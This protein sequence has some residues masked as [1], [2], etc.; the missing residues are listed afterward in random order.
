[1]DA[2]L[3]GYLLLMTALAGLLLII[4]SKDMGGWEE[5]LLVILTILCACAGITILM[6]GLPHTALSSESI[7]LGPI[8]LL[9]NSRRS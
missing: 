2:L 6:D 7:S 3:L 1:M 5:G 8:A 4:S 9:N